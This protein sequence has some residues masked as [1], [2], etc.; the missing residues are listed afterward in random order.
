MLFWLFLGSPQEHN[1]CSARK[2]L[3]TTNGSWLEA[4][5]GKTVA[6]VTFV[7]AAYWSVYH[8]TRYDRLSREFIRLRS[9]LIRVPDDPG[10]RYCFGA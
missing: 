6:T 4:C 10:T 2:A 1:P 7:R 9:I 3:D 5:V 8:A